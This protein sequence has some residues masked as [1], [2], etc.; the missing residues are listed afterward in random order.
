MDDKSI[1]G[2][3]IERIEEIKKGYEMYCKNMA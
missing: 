3:T 1:M 2:D